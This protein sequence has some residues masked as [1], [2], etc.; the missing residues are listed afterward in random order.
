[1][2]KLLLILLALLPFVSKAQLDTVW[3][4]DDYLEQYIFPPLIDNSIV[5]SN[6]IDNVGISGLQTFSCIFR[7]YN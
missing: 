7:R 5:R 1:M 3:V 2:K 6:L 4:G